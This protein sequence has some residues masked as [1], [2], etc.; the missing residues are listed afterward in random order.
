MR[1]LGNVNLDAVAE[2]EELMGRY[3]FLGGQKED[4][5]RAQAELY[6]VIDQLTVNMKEIFASEFAKLNAYFGETF[7]EIFG[8]GHAELR[9]ADT[10]DILNC[11]IE[12]RVSPPGKALKT[13]TL[14]SGGEK[15]FVAIALYFAILKVRPTPFCVLDE[16]EAAL[17][18]VNVVRFA[19][20]V[21]RLTGSTQFIVITH[22]RGTMEEADMLYGVTMQEQGVSKLLML[23][24]A[25]AEQ[26][27]GIRIK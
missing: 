10:S 16:I 12:I 5:E 6:K 18:D 27:L 24:L 9:L 4:L 26:R 22:R 19:K 15:A 7:R 23:N 21:R 1:A 20:Y 11:G 13:I 2:F 17:D 25:E 3:T 14:L 8:G